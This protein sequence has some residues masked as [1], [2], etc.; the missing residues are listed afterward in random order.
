MLKNIYLSKQFGSNIKST[1]FVHNTGNRAIT[2]WKPTNSE[3]RQ[4]SR[5]ITPSK[6][7]KVIPLNYVPLRLASTSDQKPKQH[8]FTQEFYEERERVRR[9]TISSYIKMEG[10]F[11]V[12]ASMIGGFAYWYYINQDNTYEENPDLPLKT[13]TLDD[14]ALEFEY[15]RLMQYNQMLAKNKEDVRAWV[16]KGNVLLENNKYHEALFCFYKAVRSDPGNW[17]A[18]YGKYQVYTALKY[19][20]HALHNLKSAARA[21]PKTHP[22]ATKLHIDLG[23]ELSKKN[24]Y[25]EAIDQYDEALMIDPK[26]TDA[27]LDKGT[28]YQN[29]EEYQ[30]AKESFGAALKL[31]P[32]NPKVLYGYGD[33]LVH[34]GDAKSGM[35][36]LEKAQIIDPTLSYPVKNEIK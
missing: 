4:F 2:V 30:L 3:L 16:G 12:V 18:Y 19:D 22:R 8:Q 32:G 23:A 6:I 28:A 31:E 7:C 1:K 35:V 17:E 14:A 20:A 13:Y 25:K 34:L 5:N 9:K 29:M 36:F 33:S 11:I 15:P 10:V 24:K 21:I 26:C 27:Y